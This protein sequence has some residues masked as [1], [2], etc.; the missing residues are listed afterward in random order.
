MLILQY[1]TIYITGLY[2]LKAYSYSGGE[3]PI[4]E[5]R[6]RYHWYLYIWHLV[7]TLPHK[8]QCPAS[9]P[10]P[11]PRTLAHT[12]PLPTTLLC[13]W[14]DFI[15]WRCVPLC[16]SINLSCWYLSIHKIS[17]ALKLGRI[18]TIQSVNDIW[19]IFPRNLLIAL[20]CYINI[21]RIYTYDI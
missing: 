19:S 5:H 8:N 10:T 11:L 12:P 21:P 6:L 17:M 1:L 4:P 13:W 20:D 3:V 9:V 2:G 14:L 16:N 15:P 18:I 7:T